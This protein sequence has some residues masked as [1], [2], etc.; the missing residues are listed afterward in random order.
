MAGQGD[1]RKRLWITEIGWNT[2]TTQWVCMPPFVSQANQAAYLETSWNIFLG[3]PT[4][5]GEV[6]V[7]KVFWFD[8]QD[9]GVRVDSTQCPV[10][11]ATPAGF[12][13]A[14][15]YTRVRLPLVTPVPGPAQPRAAPIVIDA[16]WG[17]VHGDYV[18]KPSYHAYRTY[19][20]PDHVY[21]PLAL[22]R[23]AGP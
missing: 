10:A 15:S 5:P 6:L 16:W 13:A 1:G 19:G 9:K 20:W 14:E 11:T 23:A 18:P 4:S 12:E 3:E 7:D 2:N 8:Y 17:V 22:K 21:L